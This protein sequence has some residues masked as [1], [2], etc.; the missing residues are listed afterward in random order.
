MAG[1]IIGSSWVSGGYS[2]WHLDHDRRNFAI[3]RY[4]ISSLD[5]SFV[6]EVSK[7]MG[8]MYI[9]DG[10]DGDGRWFHVPPYF[11][12]LVATLDR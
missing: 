9:T 8:L 2:G 4:D 11:D 6:T 7:Y 12:D 10:N 5:T 1:N 3:V